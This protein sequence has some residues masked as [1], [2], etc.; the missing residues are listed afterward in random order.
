VRGVIV[1]SIGVQNK[2]QTIL[3]ILSGTIVSI[4]ITLVLILVFALLIRFFNINDSLIFPVNQVI[5]VISMLV[6]L[7]VVLKK[8]RSKGFL[9]GLLFGFIYYIL[10]F[11]IFSVLQGSISIDVNNFIDL[12]LTSLMGGLIGL[13]LINII[14][15]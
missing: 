5:K 2:K 11:I 3:S 9:N 7:I 1:S 14:K 13:I 15:K 6:G 10:S 12:L 4:A 8:T